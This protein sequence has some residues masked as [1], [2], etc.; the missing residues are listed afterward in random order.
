MFWQII[1]TT[2]IVAL[3]ILLGGGSLVCLGR[4]SW[5]QTDQI[6]NG[7]STDDILD[8]LEQEAL[9]QV[10]PEASEGSLARG[11]LSCFM[12]DQYYHL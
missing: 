9:P 4:E 3:G 8:H 7:N 6:Q 11:N 1:C 5:A 12:V 2:V 10:E